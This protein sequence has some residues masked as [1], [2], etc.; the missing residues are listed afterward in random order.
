M[1]RGIDCM[2]CFDDCG[3]YCLLVCCSGVPKFWNVIDVFAF[4]GFV[5]DFR[6]IARK[7]VALIV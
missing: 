2:V 6:M 7:V 5:V 1:L 4:I 3:W